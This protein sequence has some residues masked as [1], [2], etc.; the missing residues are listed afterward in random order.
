MYVSAKVEGVIGL[1]AARIS[2]RELMVIDASPKSVRASINGA[3]GNWFP[4][5]GS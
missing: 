4:E 5:A 2:T 1:P 3:V